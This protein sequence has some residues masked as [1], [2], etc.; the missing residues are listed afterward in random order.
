MYIKKTRSRTTV[1][2]SATI[3]QQQLNIDIRFWLCHEEPIFLI[4]KSDSVMALYIGL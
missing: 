3:D 2:P 4:E 1:K